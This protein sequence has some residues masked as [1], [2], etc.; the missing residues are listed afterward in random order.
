[1]PIT[2]A[3]L[4]ASGALHL[5]PGSVVALIAAV[6]LSAC[7]PPPS[8][9]GRTAVATAHRHDAS[10]KTPNLILIVLDTARGDRV[11]HNG[12]SRLTTPHIDAIARDGVTYRRAHSV[13]PWTLPS[14]MSMFT[15]LLPSQHGATWSAFATPADASLADLVTRSFRVADPAHL[16]P[17]RLRR[18]GY[19]TVGFSDNA[20]IARRT[21]FDAGFDHF[22]EMW[23]ARRALTQGYNW[24]A[25]Q[26]R[27]SPDVDHGDAGR[28]LM[29]FKRHLL[30]H[31]PLREPFFLFFNFIDPHYPYSPPRPFRYA[32]SGDRTLGER[33]ARFR[34]SEMSMQAGA[35]PVDVQRLSPFYDAELAYVDFVVGQLMTWLRESGFYEESLIVITSDHGEHLGEDGRFSHQFSVAE[36]LLHVPLV[37]KYPGN[38]ASGSV[39]DDPLVSTLDL[40][41]TLL[42]AAGLSG[43]DTA[44]KRTAGSP[45]LPG[46]SLDLAADRFERAALIAEY[47]YSLPYLRIH[48]EQFPSFDVDDNRVLRRVV[49]TRDGRFE[50]VQREGEARPHPSEPADAPGREQ[51]ARALDTYLATLGGRLFEDAGQS[52]DPDTLERLKSLGYIR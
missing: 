43:A 5:Y 33:I 12:Y 34:F 3:R 16:L 24:L 9:R 40:Y 35:R 28:E 26:V 32:F 51:A 23:Q 7:G 36:E 15:G 1:M 44:I 21:G 17:E 49:Y 47:D 31:G 4:F 8:T 41:E 19:S 13:A 30:R 45:A 22:Y 50:F 42:R 52:A 10:A 2:R 46:F 27:S 38:R 48:K 39:N 18:T 29:E 11:S 25:P 14:H 20:W 37:V 6:L